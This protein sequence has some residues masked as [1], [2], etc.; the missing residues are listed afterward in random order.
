MESFSFIFALL[1]LLGGSGHGSTD[2]V[3]AL[4]TDVYW[5]VKHVT[6]GV[7]SN[8]WKHDADVEQAGREYR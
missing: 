5:R 4:P 2:L 3:K 8:N 7:S 6:P 1:M